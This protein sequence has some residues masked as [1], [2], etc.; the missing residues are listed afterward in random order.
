FTPRGADYKASAHEKK[1]TGVVVR[2]YL[3]HHQ[4]MTMTALANAILDSVMVRRFHA[5]PRIQG[6]ELLLQEKMTIL[7]PISRPRPAEETHAPPPG[8]PAA[9]ARRFRS[10]HTASPHAHFLSNGNF[11]SVLTN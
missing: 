1:R 11:I 7:S 10:P 6:T 5:D 2:T 8:M 3:A 4:G 9:A